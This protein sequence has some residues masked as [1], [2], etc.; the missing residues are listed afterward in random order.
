MYVSEEYI[1]LE[2]FGRDKKYSFDEIMGYIRDNKN[3]FAKE[4]KQKSAGFRSGMKEL[5]F[6]A[7]KSSKNIRKH[8]DN[9][10]VKGLSNEIES[11]TKTVDNTVMRMLI[12]IKKEYIT[13]ES[14]EIV[15]DI[16]YEKIIEKQMLGAATFTLVLAFNTFCHSII[17]YVFFGKY[18]KQQ[19]LDLTNPI[20]M[21][22]PAQKKRLDS[23]QKNV[24]SVITWIVAPLSEE[25]GRHYAV[26]V[27][28]GQEFT[29]AINA[30][31]FIQYIRKYRHILPL[32]KLI[33]ARSLTAGMHQFNYYVQ[34]YFNDHDKPGTGLAL[35]ILFHFS[36]NFTAIATGRKKAGQTIF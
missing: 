20:L 25:I 19:N 32:A 24:M 14:Y 15:E 4:L 34:K 2:L 31:E 12:S 29:N 21:V 1:F 35:A 6:I 27:G 28:L 22:T 16:N 10:D 30:F 5:N 23:G 3:K 36:W 18:A 13:T 7:K 11:T 33:I 26:R 17:S 8:I 9:K